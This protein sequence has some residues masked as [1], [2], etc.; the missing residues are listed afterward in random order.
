VVD[1][2]MYI[3]ICICMNKEGMEVVKAMGLLLLSQFSFQVLLYQFQ[4]HTLVFHHN[5]YLKT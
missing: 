4:F 3:N 2:Y 5:E 1:I